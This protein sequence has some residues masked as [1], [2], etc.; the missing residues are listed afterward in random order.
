MKKF[1]FSNL[2]DVDRISWRIDE[3]RTGLSGAD[4]TLLA[5]RTAA[6]WFAPGERGG[7]FKLPLWRRPMV[8]SFPDLIARK[9]PSGETL[10]SIETALLLYYFTIA[11]G[12]P[13]SKEWISFADLPDGRFYNQAFHGYTGKELAQAFKN[14]Q[15]AFERAAIGLSGEHLALG[16]AAFAFQ[17][18]PRVPLCVV[19]W[20]GD[21]EFSSSAQVLF[22]AAAS[23]YLT[24]DSYAILGSIIAHR[25]IAV[26]D[27]T[28]KSLGE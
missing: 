23:H 19:F 27:A 24:T 13:L 18:L 10:S 16:D 12:F 17:A 11:D 8:V 26:K 25:L 6:D 21:E 4:P 22:D 14:D 5:Y 28:T 3:L 7:Y 1:D 2:A 9:W 20:Q 15:V